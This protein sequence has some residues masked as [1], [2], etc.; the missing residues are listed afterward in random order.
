MIPNRN[1]LQLCEGISPYAPDE[2]LCRVSV[3]WRGMKLPK[4]RPHWISNLSGK[5]RKSRV[6]SEK[7]G[8]KFTLTRER[9]S[10]IL[11]GNKVAE[12]IV[13]K[14]R[15]F[16]ARKDPEAHLISITFTPEDKRVTFGGKS[17]LR[18]DHWMGWSR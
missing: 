3:E 13:A 8:A 14:A 2:I 10:E 16:V 18:W 15:G 5:S 1:R 12:E 11:T 6:Q 4:Q 9:I 17:V 7:L